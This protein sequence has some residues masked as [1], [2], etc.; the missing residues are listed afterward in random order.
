[1]TEPL[2]GII[3]I[4]QAAARNNLES[5]SIRVRSDNEKILN[6]TNLDN[7]KV[8]I[9]AKGQHC[10]YCQMYNNNPCYKTENFFFYLNPDPGGPNNH[11]QWN[12]NCDTKRGDFNTLVIRRNI[13]KDKS[14]FAFRDQYRDIK[15]AN[16]YDIQVFCPYADP[17]IEIS[18]IRE[19]PEHA[20]TELLA[21]MAQVEQGKPNNTN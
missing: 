10:T 3:I 5:V 4:V 2:L 12:A 21:V 1:M 9:L 14:L 16:R 17:S 8:F 19:F 20:V 13:G 6:K 15:F 11:P 7:I 18:Q